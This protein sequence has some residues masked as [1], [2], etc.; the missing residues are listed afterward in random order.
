MTT[1]TLTVLFTDIV[2]STELFASLDRRR[3][4]LVLSDHFALLGE[5][6]EHRGGRAV[7]NLG[8]G[9]MVVFPCGRDAIECAVAM[10]RATARQPGGD[11]RAA[12]SIRVGISSGDVRVENGDCFGPAVVEASRLCD[13]A[14]GTQVLL[15]ES[16][17]LLARDYQRLGEVGQLDLK[18][19][20]EP[21]RVWEAHWSPDIAAPVRVVLADDAVLVREGIRLVLEDAGIEVVGQTSDSRGLMRLIGELR[22]D[23]AIVDVRMPP[24][25]TIE[26]L[27][28]AEQIRAQHPATHV[29]VLSMEIEPRY[30][31]RLHASS[32]T[33]IG[34]LLKERVAN[35]REFA[36][37]A[38]RVAAGGTAF[39][40][41]FGI[42][43]RQSQPHARIADNGT[44]DA[45]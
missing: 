45:A 8:D 14:R 26:G 20:P 2:G 43:D 16:T 36:E 4:G 11:G 33:G 15:S 29:L 35:V 1:E 13:R 41:S 32:P 6:I 10:Q 23:L 39:E 42:P 12:L 37:A 27:E 7:K 24:T 22:P 28:A 18:G 25:H 34:Y 38:R 44:E 40:P 30:A 21:T 9:L 3:G 5:E 19:L 17:R 31:A